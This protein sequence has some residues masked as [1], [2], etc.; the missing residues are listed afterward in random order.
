MFGVDW[1]DPQT[2]WL[3]ATNLG[4]GL[5]CLVALAAIGYGIVWDLVAKRRK[6]TEPDLDREVRS[7]LETMGAHAFHTPEL[8]LT[9]ADGGEPETPAKPKPEPRKTK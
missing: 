8:G 3:N 6:A 2:L 1:S 5:I 7:M 9:M 4:L